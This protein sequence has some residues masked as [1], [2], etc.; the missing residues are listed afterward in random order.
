MD[1]FTSLRVDLRTLRRPA[2]LYSAVLVLS[3]ACGAPGPV[4]KLPF[5]PASAS[6]NPDPTKPG[7]YPVGVRTVTWE[8][9]GRRKPDGSPRILV[10]E[11]WYP[12]IQDT[13]G[14]EGVTYDITTVFTDAQK[15]NLAGAEVPLLHT[16]AVRDAPPAKSHGPFPLVLF[17]HGHGAIRWQSTYYTV[18]LASHGYVVASPDHEGGTLYDAVRN[19]L[20]N[21]AAGLEARPLDI[22]HVLNRL[23]R[24]KADDPLS[25]LIDFE[26]IG[27]SGHSFGALTSLRLAVTEPRIK[28]IVPQAPPAAD[29][30]WLGLPT[31]VELGI[32]VMVQAAHEDRT[33]KWDEHI[34]PTWP[35]LKK[36]RW[37]VDI[38]HGGH[39]TFSDLCGFDLVKMAGTIQI[40]IPGANLDNVLNDGCGPTAT[41]AAVAQP[42]ANLFAV[43]F[44]N[45]HLRGSGQAKAALTQAAAEAL[46]PGVAVVT[47]D[48]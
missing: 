43:G 16:S 30:C 47:A 23:T 18:L 27:M 37:L 24:L 15:A 46:S 33:L 4:D 3:A 44:F 34:A 9:S 48:P 22:Q 2:P 39:F 17:S 26:R 20:F 12:A 7:P 40:E 36:P 19:Q 14:K 1:A 10:T 35:L 42:I 28:A 6:A 11:L 13:R 29:I 8:D 21:S 5:Q 31:P 32:P 45:A 41:P 38:T 25:G